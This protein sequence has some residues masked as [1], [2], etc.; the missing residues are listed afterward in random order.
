MC[1]L[2]QQADADLRELPFYAALETEYYRTLFSA[3]VLQTDATKLSDF[4]L[5][6]RQIVQRERGRFLNSRHQHYPDFEHLL[7]KRSFGLSGVPL[8][9]YWDDRDVIRSQA[10]LRTYR[11]ERFGITTDNR[12]CVFRTAEYSGNKILVYLP[13]NLSWNEKTLSFPMPDLSPERLQVCVDAIIAFDPEWMLLP[14]SIALMLVDNIA[15]NRKTPPPSLRYIELCG[16]TFDVQTETIIRDTFHAQTANVYATQTSG[17]VA[18]S[19]AH[20][21]LHV[22][23]EN[24]TVE[25]IRAGKPVVD[26]EGDVYITSLQNTAMPLIRLKTDDRGLLRE[27]PCPC[28]QNAPVFRLTQGRG[29]GFITAASGRKISAFVL[30]SLSEYTH[31]EVSRCIANIRFRQTGHD[32]IDVILGAKP[33]FAGWE[34]EVSR[35]FLGQIQDPELKQMQ[36]NFIF[37]D[38]RNSDETGAGDYPLFKL[39]EGAEQ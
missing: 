3:R 22:F 36:W 9:I 37:V 2:G 13:Q 10:F 5:L 26:E 4:P 12:C 35:V 14:P 28:G 15:M 20:G 38:P 33:V 30:R 16:E 21:Q 39:W 34:E 23:S 11:K 29:C 1:A 19:C 32:S 31:E 27:A 18:A 25:V 6:T 7:I 8:E 24:A 17:A